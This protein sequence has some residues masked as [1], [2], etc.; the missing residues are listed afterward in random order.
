MNFRRTVAGVRWIALLFLIS[1]AAQAE[2]TISVTLAPSPAGP[3]P[4]GTVITWTATVQDT[5]SGAHEY[6]FSVGPAAGPV[7]DRSGLRP[8]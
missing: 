4:V 6:Q 7:S 8:G 3:Q 1:M 5:A 2:A